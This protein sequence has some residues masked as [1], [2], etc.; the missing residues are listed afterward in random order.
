MKRNTTK[1]S[2]LQYT[3]HTHAHTRAKLPSIYLISRGPSSQHENEARHC[4]AA[5]SGEHEFLTNPL[6]PLVCMVNGGNMATFSMEFFGIL[7]AYLDRLV[8]T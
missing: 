2:A 1:C 4:G 5:S 3:N 6:F 7:L 8:A